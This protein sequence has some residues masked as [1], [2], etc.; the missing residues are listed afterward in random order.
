MQEKLSQVM[1]MVTISIKGKGITKD[2]N[3]RDM[4]AS[5]ENNDGQLAVPNS[6]DLCEQEKLRKNLFGQS[7]YINMQQRCNLLDKKLKVIKGVN[8]LENVDLR[9]LSLVPDVVIPPK[10]KMPNV[11]ITK[12]LRAFHKELHGPQREGSIPDRR[13]SDQIQRICQWSSKALR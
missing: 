9:E 2:P 8:D 6:N 4:L 11:D 5:W 7:E 12:E 3:S 13:R 1:E 10:F